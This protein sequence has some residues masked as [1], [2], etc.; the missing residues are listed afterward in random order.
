MSPLRFAQYNVPVDFYSAFMVYCTY[1]E[2]F[3]AP[4]TKSPR[5]E[6]FQLR[7]VRNCFNLRCKIFLLHSSKTMRSSTTVKVFRKMQITTE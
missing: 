1:I 7:K 6:N 5:R 4:V 2:N 3:F